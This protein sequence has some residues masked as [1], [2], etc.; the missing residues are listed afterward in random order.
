MQGGRCM[1]GGGSGDAPSV[2]PRL[3]QPV[4]WRPDRACCSVCHWLCVVSHTLPTASPSLCVPVHSVLCCSAIG[5][6]TS[7]ATQLDTD[8]SAVDGLREGI[9]G[10]DDA[11]DKVRRAVAHPLLS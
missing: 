7:K 9:K 8:S 5:E 2:R 1:P 6:L 10:M 3:Q 4:A 11:I